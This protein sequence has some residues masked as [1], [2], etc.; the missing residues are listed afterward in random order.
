MS[1]CSTN[2]ANVSAVHLNINLCGTELKD[3]RAKI[4]PPTLKQRSSPHC[5]LSLAC[6]KERQKRRMDSTLIFG[7]TNKSNAGHGSSRISRMD[8]F[9][10]LIHADL[11]RFGLH[12]L[13]RLAQ[14][15]ADVHFALSA[16]D[17]EPDRVAGPVIVHDLAEILLVLNVLAVNRHDQVAAHHDRDVADVGALGSATQARA[18]GGATRHHLDD[19]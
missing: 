3:R 10:L 2:S 1:S 13:A 17:G 9:L 16:I 12:L 15:Y 14:G 8:L 18:V 5:R 11:W 7:R 4:F 6:G 19:Q